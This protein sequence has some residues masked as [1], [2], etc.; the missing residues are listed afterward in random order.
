MSFHAR[1][2]LRL[3]VLAGLVLSLAACQRL[4]D[5]GAPDAIQGQDFLRI[6]GQA[7]LAA[8]VLILVL[9]QLVVGFGGGSVG[10]PSL[11]ELAWLAGGRRRVLQTAVAQLYGNGQLVLLSGGFAKAVSADKGAP[12]EPLEK[13]VWATLGLAKKPWL[14]TKLALS[15]CEALQVSLRAKG[16]LLEEGRRSLL[17]LLT[18]LLVLP[19]LAVGSLRFWH[20]LVAGRP[21]GFLALLLLVYIG[22]GALLLVRIPFASQRG[23][24]CLQ[25]ARSTFKNQRDVEVSYSD[26]LL[27][28]RFALYG[29]AALMASSELSRYLGGPAAFSSGGSSGG[30]SGCSSCSSGGSDS[31]SGGGGGGC[32]G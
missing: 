27:A 2:M 21:V 4:V 26:P 28:R 23:Q 17:R 24:R 5:G 8:L 6:F 32:G 31:S 18:A 11:Y 20:G 15:E 1:G 29:L 10:Q 7:G 30:D 22:V 19:L 9:H 25:Q 3:V 12:R 16:L 13:A 14:Q